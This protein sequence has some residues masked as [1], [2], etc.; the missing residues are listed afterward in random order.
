MS[1]QRGSK[2]LFVPLLYLVLA[3]R[4]FREDVT[5][6]LLI[7]SADINNIRLLVVAKGH[8]RLAV[9]YVKFAKLQA[10]FNRKGRRI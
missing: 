1:A 6:F 5:T 7:N 4:E 2:V 8:K 9:L 10:F 3:M